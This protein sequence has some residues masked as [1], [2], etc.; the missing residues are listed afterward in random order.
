MCYGRTEN[1]NLTDPQE[2]EKAI[3]LGEYIRNG[4]YYVSYRRILH[5]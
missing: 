3:K 1:R 4:E 5:D 2:I